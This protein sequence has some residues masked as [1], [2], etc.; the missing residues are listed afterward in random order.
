MLSK[1][2]KPKTKAELIR[3]LQAANFRSFEIF[4]GE[5]A[6]RLNFSARNQQHQKQR[7]SSV[8]ILLI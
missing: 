7:Y 4:E 8:V 1:V 2:T 6:Q 5:E 3:A